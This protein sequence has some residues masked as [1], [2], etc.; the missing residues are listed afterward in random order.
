MAVAG[1]A[2]SAV[3]VMVIGTA[4][5]ALAAAR[6]RRSVSS[7]VGAASRHVVPGEHPGTPQSSTATLAVTVTGPA[8]AGSSASTT[9][10][11]PSA[12]PATGGVTPVATLTVALS[13]AKAGP[14]GVAVTLS[15][16]RTGGGGSGVGVVVGGSTATVV[17]GVVVGVVVGADVGVDVEVAGEVEG[18]VERGGA[19]VAGVE[20][21]AAVL[22]G[23]EPTDA[24]AAGT[25][26]P[27]DTVAAVTGAA[28]GVVATLGGA[29]DG[30]AG[31]ATAAATVVTG[32]APSV[33][34][35]SALCWLMAAMPTAPATTAAAVATT[36][37]AWVARG[38]GPPAQESQ[39]AAA[40]DAEVGQEG[41]A[42]HAEQHR[43]EHAAQAGADLLELQ[44]HRGAPLAA[45][46]VLVDLAPVTG[47]QA[48]AHVGT[49]LGDGLPAR[50]GGRELQ[51]GLEVG[52][53][54]ALP[55][56]VGEGGHGVGGE[57]QERAH[58]G[59][60]SPFHL[61][62]PQHHL[63][64]LGQGREGGRHHAG[65]LAVGRDVEEGQV[66]VLRHL[67]GHVDAAVLAGLVVPGVSDA[68]HEVRAERDLGAGA[69][70]Q[71]RQDPW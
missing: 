29:V 4:S 54:Q 67:T 58:L 28:I 15:G 27:P 20:R 47:R 45:L 23:E 8:G 11:R 14:T 46:Q 30:G 35:R 6:S 43:D 50:I 48:V 39:Q 31:E 53:A 60:R 66:D 61:R 3:V 55:G 52:L 12:A 42:G 68:R 19:V 59:R 37:P 13:P 64:A 33:L 32:A 17:G 49:E 10:E 70:L 69:A 7:D 24:G 38:V 56:P 44:Q 40:A 25:I 18:V 16:T 57:A 41:G 36:T 9:R 62:V 63:P 65:V 1:A 2:P 26:V 22:A 5:P 71:G 51:V 21:R 34:T